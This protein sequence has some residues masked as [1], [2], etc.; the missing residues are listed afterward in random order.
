MAKKAIE[1]QTLRDRI[2]QD[3]DSRLREIEVLSR[4]IEVLGKVGELF[5]ALMDKLVMDHVK[6][7]ESVV[8][9]AL[10]SIFVDQDLWFEAEVSQ[11]YN[12]M[13]I[14]FYIRQEDKRMSIKAHPLD[15]FGGGPTCIASLILKVLAM[16]RLNKWPLIAL[17]ETLNAVSDDYIDRTGKFLRELAH[18]TG[19]SFLLVSQ[20]PA[21]LDHAVIGYKASEVENAEGYRH[22]TM[23]AERQPT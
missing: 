17:D 7:I 20:K 21:F 5:R 10:R 8:T 4:R 23:T 12:K 3:L 15:A 1:L 19:F 11:R 14:D 9:E 18:K 22:L 13:A 6:S 2:Q 16:R